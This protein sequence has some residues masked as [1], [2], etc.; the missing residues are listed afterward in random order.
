MKQ[1]STRILDNN[2]IRLMIILLITNTITLIM[3]LGRGGIDDV[4]QKLCDSEFLDD[5]IKNYRE[6]NS[7]SP[8]FLG[9]TTGCINKPSA[10]DL[11]M[12]SF[13]RYS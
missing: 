5:L 10:L 7:K 6:G 8:F 9:P 3:A 4:T 1:K 12:A 2:F 13:I 11:C